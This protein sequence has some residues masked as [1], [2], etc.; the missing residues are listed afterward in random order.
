MDPYNSVG[1]LNGLGAYPRLISA[2]IGLLYF[3]F[4]NSEQ[5]QGRTPGKR[6]LH[7]SVENQAAKTSVS[8]L[9]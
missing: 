6:L 7:L 1:L 2:A 9:T 4:F 5:G 3:G 8:G